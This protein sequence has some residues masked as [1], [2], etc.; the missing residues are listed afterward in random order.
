MKYLDRL[1]QDEK[2]VKAQDAKTHAAQAKASVEQKISGLKAQQAVLEGQ[3][4]AALGAIPF[5]VENVVG[6]SRKQAQVA[7]DIKAFENILTELF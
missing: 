4:N 3:F 5:N 7:E 2:S 1:N 6:I